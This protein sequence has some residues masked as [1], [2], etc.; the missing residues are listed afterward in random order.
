MKIGVLQ[1]RLSEPVNGMIQEFPEKT[2]EDEFKISEEIGLYGIEWLITKN[3]FRNNPIFTHAIESKNILS[4]CVD[5]MVNK[6]FYKKSFLEKNLLP[7]LDI[8]TE[9]NI[10]K[11]VFPL[12]EESSIDDKKIRDIFI[13]NISIISEKYKSIFFCFEFETNKELVMD[14]VSKRENFF[15]TY[16]TGNFTSHYKDSVDHSEL[17]NYFGGKIKNVHIKDR[18]YKGVTKKYGDG[19]T[20]FNLI[21]K[22][23]KDINYDGCFIL[24]L[25]R[26]IIGEEKK[27]INESY[28]K[29]K[30]NYIF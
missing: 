26:D 5:N 29:I 27:Y 8:M 18:T 11:L 28:R 24:Q 19:D 3:N 2:W 23:L 13:E 12:L 14:V 25:C 4:V 30:N 7:I 22:T 21:F 6:N 9:K 15:I 17:I 20:D 10:L 1:G 16:D